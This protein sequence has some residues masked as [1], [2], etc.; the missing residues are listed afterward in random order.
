MSLAEYSI[1]NETEQLIEKAK[2]IL[3]KE[4]INTVIMGHSHEAAGYLKT[5]YINTGCWTR[6]YT[7]I[8]DIKLNAWSILQKM[9]PRDLSYNLKY[10]EIVP[11]NKNITFFKIFKEGIS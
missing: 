8:D 5:G 7:H 1:K 4:K 11:G 3:N 9:S 10:V 2:K 6:N